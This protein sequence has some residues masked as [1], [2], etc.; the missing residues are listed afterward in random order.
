MSVS[1]FNFPTPLHFDPGASKQ[2]ASQVM[3]GAALDVAIVVGLLATRPG[4]AIEYAWDHPNVRRI[5]KELPYFIELP[6]TLCQ[7]GL[8]SYFFRGVLNALSS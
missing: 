1:K 7:G 8:R 5:E 4:D 6:T 2:V 3:A